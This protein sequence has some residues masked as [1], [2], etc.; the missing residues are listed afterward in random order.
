MLLTLSDISSSTSLLG[1]NIISVCEMLFVSICI[2]P[3]ADFAI[4]GE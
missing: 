1:V 4:V 3:L 2:F